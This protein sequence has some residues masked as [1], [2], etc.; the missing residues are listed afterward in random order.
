MINEMSQ[1][2]LMQEIKNHTHNKN[3]THY[4]ERLNITKLL[5]LKKM[6]DDLTSFTKTKTTRRNSRNLDINGIDFKTK[7]NTNLNY[8]LTTLFK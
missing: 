3:T 5:H 4:K 7:L 8:I 2:E 6:D 1:I